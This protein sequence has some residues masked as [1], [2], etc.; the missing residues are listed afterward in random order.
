MRENGKALTKGKGRYMAA[1]GAHIAGAEKWS[2]TFQFVLYTV[3]IYLLKCNYFQQLAHK[4]SE[5]NVI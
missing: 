2:L 1:Y 4:F 3:T 5:V